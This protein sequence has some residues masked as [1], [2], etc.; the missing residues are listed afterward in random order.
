MRRRIWGERGWCPV[1]RR[2]LRLTKDGAVFRHGY[3]FRRAGRGEYRVW[4]DTQGACPGSGRKAEPLGRKFE[5]TPERR[6]IR[7]RIE[8]ACVTDRD[9]DELEAKGFSDEDVM[10]VMSQLGYTIGRAADDSNEWWPPE[11]KETEDGDKDEVV[12]RG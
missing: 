4:V 2:L 12:C 8:G 5:W 6:D 9:V 1:C 11:R 10:E 3:R 7:R